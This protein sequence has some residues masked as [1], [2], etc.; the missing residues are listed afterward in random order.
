MHPYRLY[1]IHIGFTTSISALQHPY[2]LA[3]IVTLWCWGVGVP[4][5][6]VHVAQ[7]AVPL[8]RATTTCSGLPGEGSGTLR[9]VCP[10]GLRCAVWD[11]L[12]AS[13]TRFG[14]R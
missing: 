10:H 7:Y 6:L 4:R 14:R 2:R 3:A 8:P 12:A 1:N 11:C 13:A 9:R 5:L